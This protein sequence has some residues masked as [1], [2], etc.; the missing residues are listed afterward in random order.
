MKISVEIEDA[1]FDKASKMLTE[2][3]GGI[4]QASASVLNK[5]L[6]AGRTTGVREVTKRYTIKAKDVRPAIELRRAKKSDLGAEMFISGTNIS[7]KRFAHKPAAD[8]TGANRKPVRMARKVGAWENVERGFVWR[9]HVFQREGRGRLPIE[10]Q[11]G[12]SVPGMFGNDQIVDKIEDKM[13]E[14]VDKQLEHET[15]RILNKY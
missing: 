2:V 7:M 3:P 14:V 11:F 15:N 6:Q 9:G 4:E 12:P 5:A 10:K 8:T 1:A 13:V